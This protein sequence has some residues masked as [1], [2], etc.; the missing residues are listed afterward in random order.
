MSIQTFHPIE[1]DDEEKL[2]FAID[3]GLF[4]LQ[5]LS[6]Y[7]GIDEFTQKKY[8]TIY[9]GRVP[10]YLSFFNHFSVGIG[11]AKENEWILNLA[12]IEY[13]IMNNA[14][15]FNWC[16]LPSIMK[17]KR[18]N[19][20][21][22]KGHF[23]DFTGLVYSEKKND[24]VLT[25]SFNS[26]VD[27]IE[28]NIYSDS[29]KGIHLT[30]LLDINSINNVDIKYELISNDYIETLDNNFKKEMVIK[31]N[32]LLRDYFENKIKKIVIENNLPINFTN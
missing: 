2:K 9:I 32:N 7:A 29:N 15:P 14:I 6:K 24:F 20:T 30:K 5:I 19:N 4:R 21:I 26:R 31:Y 3:R 8:D 16:S 1:V 18:S 28:P 27:D 11:Y 10:C 23:N 13:I 12:G 25:A 17:I 22:Q